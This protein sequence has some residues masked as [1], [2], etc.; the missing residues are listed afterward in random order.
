MTDEAR[1]QIAAHVAGII[2]GVGE[3]ATREGLQKTPDR[4]ARAYEDLT[5]GYRMDLRTLVNEAIFSDVNEDGMVIVRDIE[6]YS[7]CEH[8][9]LPFY[10][11]AH[12]GYIPRNK[13]IGLSKIPRIV[14]MFARRFQVQERLTEQIRRAVEDV[15]DPLGVGVVMK[16]KH[17]CMMMRG[18]EKQNSEVF[19]SSMSGVFHDDSRTRVEFLDLIRTGSH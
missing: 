14:D 2:G 5:R 11:R 3:D 17:M 19:T 13:I 15:L 6:V 16:C 10:G 7:L 18:V 8:H 12:V 4:A 1:R 9:L